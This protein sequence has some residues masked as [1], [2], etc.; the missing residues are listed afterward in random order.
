[1]KIV[2][3]IDND[4]TPKADIFLIDVAVKQ[5]KTAPSVINQIIKK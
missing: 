5:V 2:Q 3:V 4:S 1:M